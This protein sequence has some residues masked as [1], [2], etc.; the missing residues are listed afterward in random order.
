MVLLFLYI[1]L[2]VFFSLGAIDASTVAKVVKEVTAEEKA[3]QA[4]WAARPPLENVLNM[5]DFEV[6][7]K[8]VIPEKAWVCNQRCTT[9]RHSCYPL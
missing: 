6:I 2:D 9:E 7:A 3:R 8:A 5:H 4:A 1:D